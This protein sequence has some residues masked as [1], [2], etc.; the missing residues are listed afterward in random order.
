MTWKPQPVTHSGLVSSQRRK[1]AEFEGGLAGAEYEQLI[2]ET[3]PPEKWTKQAQQEWSRLLDEIGANP[4]TAPEESQYAEAWGLAF[5]RAR[6]ARR[7][8]I[9][10]KN[11]VTR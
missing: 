7:A 9:N 2:N 5:K 4:Y 8:D 3:C 10:R 1:E 11:T 6:A